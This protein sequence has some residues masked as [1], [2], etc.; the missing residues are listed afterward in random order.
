MSTPAYLSQPQIQRL[1]NILSE[2]LSGALL[3]PRFQRPATWSDE[4]RLHLMDSI[5]RGLPIGSFLVWRTLTLHLPT[6]EDIGGLRTQALPHVTQTGPRQYLLD[7][8][9]RLTAL[10]S[11]LAPGLASAQSTSPNTAADQESPPDPS[12]RP[13]FYDLEAQDFVLGVDAPIPVTW[14]PLAVL[15]DPSALWGFQQKLLQD[16]HPRNLINRAENLANTFKDY[17]VPVIPFLSEDLEVVTTSFKR[18]NSAGTPMGEVHMIRALTWTPDFDLTERLDDLR[19]GLADVG[20]QSTDDRILLPA[21]KLTLGLDVYKANA[22]EM[23][24]ALRARPDV[25]SEVTFYMHHA[26]HF[27][28]ERGVDSPNALPYS[29]QAVILCEW[30]RKADATRSIPSTES[31]AALRDWFW[32]TTYTERF[33]GMNSTTLRRAIEQ[34]AM[35]LQD[36]DAALRAERGAVVRPSTR[37]DYRAAR[38]RAWALR[39]AEL[40]PLDLSG[41]PINPHALLAQHGNDALPQLIH[42]RWLPPEHRYLAQGPWN[43]VLTSPLQRLDIIKALFDNPYAIPPKI[44]DS[45]AIDD[46]TAQALSDGDF[47]IALTL[48][49]QR[50]LAI[51]RAFVEGLRLTY[52]IDDA[53]PP[54]ETPT[55]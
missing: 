27:L 3:V 25:F 11:A 18:I 4:Q 26:A 10:Y 34:V 13:I 29:F 38:S 24:A 21:I 44:L 17:S 51:E 48:R 55:P 42:P 31:L 23:Q 6:Y 40:R 46:A 50:F 1:P 49:R 9:Q 53:S 33:A 16:K 43:R 12:T 14:L 39:L 2:L 28:H 7:G 47:A 41:E 36:P 54:Q 8:H 52:R 19:S 35:I 30:M 15:F 5:R 45:H 32:I 20:W 22:E 37:F